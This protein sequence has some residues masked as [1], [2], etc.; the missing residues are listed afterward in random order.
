MPRIIIHVTDGEEELTECKVMASKAGVASPS[1]V[2]LILNITVNGW[3]RTFLQ[4]ASSRP[5]RLSLRFADTLM[6]SHA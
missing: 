6:R 3:S 2:V 5:K 1:I 4:V